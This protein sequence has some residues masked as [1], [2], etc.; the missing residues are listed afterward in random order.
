MEIR[1]I[2]QS[3]RESAGWTFGGKFELSHYYHITEMKRQQSC[4]GIEKANCLYVC[5]QACPHNSPTEG[6]ALK[7]DRS[8]S[9]L[10]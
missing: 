4:G 1:E 9:K 6:L 10:N 2:A 5:V 3:S 7:V 8:V